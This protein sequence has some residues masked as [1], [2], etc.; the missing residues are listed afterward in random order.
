MSVVYSNV[1]LCWEGA[2]DVGGSTSLDDSISSLSYRHRGRTPT[3]TALL[4]VIAAP[5]V[6]TRTSRTNLPSTVRRPTRTVYLLCLL[7][8]RFCTILNISSKMTESISTDF[9]NSCS[10]PSVSLPC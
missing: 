5:A 1:V 6:P 10:E 2:A 7:F 9:V 3:P 4:P 8:C